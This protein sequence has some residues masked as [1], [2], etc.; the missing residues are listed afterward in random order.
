MPCPFFSF[1]RLEWI[2]AMGLCWKDKGWGSSAYALAVCKRRSRGSECERLLPTLGVTTTIIG[3][4]GVWLG[5]EEVEDVV[6]GGNTVDHDKL[7]EVRIRGMTAA[8]LN[9]F[10]VTCALVPD[11]YCPG[12]S[13]A[14][15]L[16]KEASLM[17]TAAR[18]RYKV[19]VSKISATVTAELSRKGKGRAKNSETSRKKRSSR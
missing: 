18:Y 17:R 3:C 9:R 6:G 1:C 4:P 12:C 10:M 11:L 2:R 16:P 19:D 5:R 7:A 15:T 8:N 14:E 13:S